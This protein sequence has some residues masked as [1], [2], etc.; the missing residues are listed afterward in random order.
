MD[1]LVERGLPTDEDSSAV[2]M[3]PSPSGY[4]TTASKVRREALRWIGPEWLMLSAS[5][6]NALF[7]TLSVPALLLVREPH[8]R[9]VWTLEPFASVWALA[10]GLSVV[11]SIAAC[12]QL[13]WRWLQWFVVGAAVVEVTWLGCVYVALVA[14]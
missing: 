1:A 9:D 5:A 8:T 11:G 10:V 13:R 7:I 14:G 4:I 12:L 6:L 2:A 3:S